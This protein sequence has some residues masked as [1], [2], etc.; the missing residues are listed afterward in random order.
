[1]AATSATSGFNT[2]LKKGTTALGEVSDL[3]GPSESRNWIDATH[4]TSDN[5]AKEYVAGLIDSGQVTGTL[6]FL[7]G[8]ATQAALRTDMLAG[9]KDSYSLTFP[10]A[11]TTVFSFTA[12]VAAVA[13]AAPKDGVLACS[14]T[15]QI[16][17]II[18]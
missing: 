4:L 17:G 10:D 3:N 1:M 8:N 14:F 16:S 9:T 18:T 12:G 6:N 2:V 7:P 11:A 15:L 5:Q 13:P